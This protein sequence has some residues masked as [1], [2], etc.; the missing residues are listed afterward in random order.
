MKTYVLSLLIPLSLG[1]SLSASAQTWSTVGGEFNSHINALYEYND[2]L[3]IGGNFTSIDG[4]AAYGLAE[5]NG[6]SISDRNTTLVDGLGVS[7]FGTYQGKLM[8]VGAFFHGAFG[9][10]FVAEWDGTDFVNSAYRL[11]ANVYDILVV[12]D[13]FYVVGYFDS[14]EGTNYRHVAKFTDGN[15]ETVGDGFD[16]P[17]GDLIMYD[18]YVT[19]GGGNG[20]QLTYFNGT[21]WTDIGT[22]GPAGA[23][24]AEFQGDLYA[25]G[26]FD[27]AVDGT[28][29]YI[30]RWD[31]TTWHDVGGGLTGGLNCARAILATPDYLYVAGQFT[32]AGGVPVE[33]IAKW[34]GTSWSAVG[35]GLP[36]EIIQCLAIYKDHLYAGPTAMA[37]TNHLY[38]FND[39]II[40]SSVDEMQKPALTF[41][42]SPNPASAS[43]HWQIFSDETQ[44]YFL[45]ITDMS[46]RIILALNSMEQNGGIDLS[47][48]SDGMY[49]AKCTA[50]NGETAA[51]MFVVSK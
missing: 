5:W 22:N 15:Y 30:A 40:I 51:K 24:M 45:Q 4:M 10:A 19:A 9:P 35:D 39:E 44:S 6:T 41:S 49:L 48:F 46:G 21:A 17:I 27:D 8:A 13:E 38:K 43:I 34:D 7:N 2:K 25:V 36:G 3:Y 16:L 18:G 11:N 1:A 14:F 28:A 12:G 23:N 31:G 37:F 32:A 33:N 47:D 50:E 20:D 42:L 29:R 26:C